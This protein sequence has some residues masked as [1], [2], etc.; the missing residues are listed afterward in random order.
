[1]NKN[2]G[3]PAPPGSTAEDPSIEALVVTNSGITDCD[4]SGPKINSAIK[5][6]K[7][8]AVK[9]PKPKARTKVA[10]K[11]EALQKH[12]DACQG[13][14]S[15]CQNKVDAIEAKLD[16]KMEKMDTKMAAMDA[17]M[18]AIQSQ[19]KFLLEE[20]TIRKRIEPSGCLSPKYR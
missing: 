14:I 16:A 19:L 18:D 4:Q 7:S 1:M 6:D 15:T 8:P 10:N 11:I 5:P 20:T 3:K 12:L 13:R 9:L 17:K 2:I